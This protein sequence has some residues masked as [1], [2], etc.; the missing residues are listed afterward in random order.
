M[1][2][3]HLGYAA[4]A[5]VAAVGFSAKAFAGGDIQAC[6]A[7]GY[8]TTYASCAS[9]SNKSST[10]VTAVETLKVAANQT[11]GLIAQRIGSFTGANPRTATGPL[12]GGLS[13]G[14]S[15]LGLG[16]WANVGYSS[17]DFDK[18]GSEFDGDIWTGMGGLD[19]KFTE[20]FIAGMAFG[21][22]NIDLETTFNRGTLKADG[23]TFAPYALYRFTKTYSVDASVGYSMVDYDLT[24]RDPLVNTS[25]TGKTDGNRYFGAVNLNGNWAEDQ[26]RFGA[27][28]GNLYVTET[29]DRFTESNGVVTGEQTTKVGQASLGGKVGYNLGMVEPYVSGAGRIYYGDA[30][31]KSD[32]LAGVGSLFYLGEMAIGGIEATTPLAADDLKQWTVTGTIRF[33][34]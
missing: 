24:R 28:L 11:A 15:E 7:E 20:Q 14:S 18:A 25:I 31:D 4:V 17:I 23:W 5:V 32:F 8:S 10:Q 26:W 9:N 3:N 22:E 27:K 33:D 29:K 6:T 2:F 21:Y 16:V 19:Y 30:D 34:F 1:R 12:K 13:G